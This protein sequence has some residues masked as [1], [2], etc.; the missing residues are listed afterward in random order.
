M[1]ALLWLLA[2]LLLLVAE[3]ASGD[4]VLVMIGTGALA[5]SGS[6]ALG[7]PF[8]A[9]AIVFAAVSILSLGVVRPAVKRRLR[10]GPTLPTGVE[11][12]VGLSAGVL[13]TV[14]ASGGRVRIDGQEWTARTALADEV[15]V[16][17]EEVIVVEIDGATAV[18]GRRLL[19]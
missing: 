7:A 14:T 6:A 11:A 10:R 16:P 3:A 8:W 18:V 9:D 17:G 19:R 1:T 4:L 13:T 15:L 2:A 5:A 12:L